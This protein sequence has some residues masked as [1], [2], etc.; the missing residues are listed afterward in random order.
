MKPTSVLT[1]PRLFVFALI[2]LCSSCGKLQERE[3]RGEADRVPSDFYFLGEKYPCYL[4]LKEGQA[5]LR[6]NCF[7]KDGVLH[8]HSSR[9][10]NL[11][12]FSGESWRDAIRKDPQVRVEIDNKT[13]TMTATAVDDEDRRKKMLRDRGYIYAWEGIT[14]FRFDPFIG[15]GQSDVRG[16]ERG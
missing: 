6:V 13:Y 1:A 2:I 12:R 10:A 11:P 3:L 4:E 5:A 8:I 15:S 16:L 9:W 7:E 14:I